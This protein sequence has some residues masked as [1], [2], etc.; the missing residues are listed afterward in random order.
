[1]NSSLYF[2]QLN[3]LP[4]LGIVVTGHA[5]WYRLAKTYR[6]VSM[7]AVTLFEVQNHVAY[8]TLNR[9]EAMNSLNPELRWSLSQHFD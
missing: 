1:M 4:A 7:S 8:I 3:Y 9:P 5:H 6:V 2:W